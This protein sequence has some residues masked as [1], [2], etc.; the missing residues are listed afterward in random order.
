MTSDEHTLSL[1]LKLATL[2]TLFNAPILVLR[3][4][5]TELLPLKM[6]VAKPRSWCTCTPRRNSS[7]VGKMTSEPVFRLTAVVSM[8]LRRCSVHRTIMC[9]LSVFIHSRFCVRYRDIVWNLFDILMDSSASL[10][11]VTVKVESSA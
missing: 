3:L 4:L 5:T 1:V 6:F 7:G 2:L 8:C 10:S 11:A 9:V